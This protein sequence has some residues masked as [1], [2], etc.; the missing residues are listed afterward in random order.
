MKE[1]TDKLQALAQR[2]SPEE[3]KTLL[4]YAEFM[5]S[6]STYKVEE[7]VTE[8]LD[9]P[10]P[11]EE[12]V[13]AAMRRLSQTYPM[14]NMDKLLHEASGLMSEH[15]MHGRAAIEVIDDLHVLFDRH[16]QDYSNQD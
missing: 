6:R 10:R 11:A 5:V 1:L 16:Y 12:S 2:L 15:L 13:V 14:L 8:P 7:T 3:Q 9:I 4:D